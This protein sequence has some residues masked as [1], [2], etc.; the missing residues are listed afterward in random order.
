MRILVHAVSTY[1]KGPAM[2]NMSSAYDL[3]RTSILG[4]A[5]SRLL[6]MVLGLVV[7]MAMRCEAQCTAGMPL[8]A[9]DYTY[10]VA[11]RIALEQ[12][13]PPAFGHFQIFR[14]RGGE[15]FQAFNASDGFDSAHYPTGHAIIRFNS[16]AEL[17]QGFGLRG[18]Q[19]ISP[20]S[21]AAALVVPPS[22]A[23]TLF[24][25]S[26]VT[27]SL[28]RVVYAGT[29]AYYGGPS[30]VGRLKS[31]GTIDVTFGTNGLTL[32]PSLGTRYYLPL[33]TIS[34]ANDSIYVT[35]PQRYITRITDAGAIDHTFGTDLGLGIFGI[36]L[37]AE[38]SFSSPTGESVS[39]EFGLRPLLLLTP[40]GDGSVVRTDAV[41]AASD[42]RQ[43]AFLIRKYFAD[44]TQDKSFGGS[45][46]VLIYSPRGASKR[47]KFPPFSKV[48]S[49]I[50]P[51]L[52]G[53]SS[54]DLGLLTVAGNDGLFLI[55]NDSTYDSNVVIDGQAFVIKLLPNG[56]IDTTFG[57]KGVVAVGNH[58]TIITEGL[59]GIRSAAL[60]GNG[61]PGNERI[62]FHLIAGPTFIAK[63]DLLGNFDGSFGTNGLLRGEITTGLPLV[64]EFNKGAFYIV[65]ATNQ[66]LNI[67]D[68]TNRTMGRILL[69]C[70][71]TVSLT[72]V[73][74]DVELGSIVSQ[75]FLNNRVGPYQVAVDG[76]KT[77]FTLQ[78]SR[79]YWFD[80]VPPLGYTANDLVIYGAWSADTIQT[81]PML[82]IRYS[83]IVAVAR[84][85]P[86]GD[87][88]RD[89]SGITLLGTS[90]GFPVW[91][92]SL[93]QSGRCV[94]SGVPFSSTVS[95]S[96][97]KPGYLF[98][99]V[100]T[101]VT[102][103]KEV[104]ISVTGCAD[105]YR[106]VDNA[107]SPSTPPAPS[108]TPTPKSSP[109]TP[110]AGTPTPRSTPPPPVES[111][112][113][114]CNYVQSAYETLTAGI[115]RMRK[116][117]GKVT[118]IVKTSAKRYPTVR[119]KLQKLA[120]KSVKALHLDLTATTLTISSVPALFLTCSGPQTPTTAE[121]I[122]ERVDHSQA[123]VAYQR[124]VRL[125]GRKI[126][127][128]AN[129]AKSI[130]ISET[131]ATAGGGLPRAAKNI[132]KALKSV[133][134]KSSLIP[135]IETRCRLNSN[136]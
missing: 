95:I 22:Q 118:Q 120:K 40:L 78:N 58:P 117:G 3:D 71:P 32:L 123:I 25:H 85:G 63:I 122:C 87:L 70:P 17:D 16:Q 1:E 129:T 77:I 76:P 55:A 91:T 89:L 10:G 110:P 109:G 62:V 101:N 66:N 90:E 19:D 128:A 107:C 56:N 13:L 61:T 35:H 108:P 46:K 68:L 47:I 31:D 72:L 37:T 38:E 80:L 121:I 48:V 133:I 126:L 130:L 64:P 59:V 14:G 94:W 135:K 12:N 79:P 4:H 33:L 44:G 21:I 53:G 92:C 11:G 9:L 115:E 6:T 88:P 82:R 26:I 54:N 105:G 7:F 136:N 86:T 36:A 104:T 52:T 125:L 50:A 83:I 127:R 132:R 113:P 114:G 74:T 65:G 27:D 67:V 81:V 42:Q 18:S 41:F 98:T 51:S 29:F 24:I 23:G 5:A 96:A 103:S 39:I 124:A 20:S 15:L 30:F 119:R 93:D 99:T 100:A 57:Q 45:G 73:P 134:A 111:P 131:P 8:L 49:Q 106:E 60:Q 116:L 112:P 84:G 69:G 75:V 34:A 97:L 2:R 28:G 43:V 102:G